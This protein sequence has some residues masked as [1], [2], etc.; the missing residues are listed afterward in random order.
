MV[1][2]VWKIATFVSFVVIVGLLTFNIIGGTKSLKAG[3]IQSLLILPFDNL[4]GDD[5]LDYVAAGLHTS[6]CGDVE[7][8]SSLRTTSKTT[9]DIIKNMNL[10]LSEM[11]IKKPTSQILLQVVGYQNMNSSSVNK[12]VPN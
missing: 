6:L 7:Q 4:T 10:S 12:T 11:A 5:Q 1:P 8:I 9:A 3:D 2:N